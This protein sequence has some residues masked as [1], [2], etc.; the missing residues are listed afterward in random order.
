MDSDAMQLLDRIYKAWP[1][2][3]D[4]RFEHYANR[5]LTHLIKLC[6]VCCI[7]RLGTTIEQED[8]I[9]ANTILS[10]TEQLMPKA[11]GEFGKSKRSEVTH[12]IMAA[13]DKSLKPITLQELWKVVHQDLE[14]RQQMVDI[15]G[16]LQMAE[17]IQAVNNGWLPNK[18]VIEESVKGSVNWDLLTPQEKELTGEL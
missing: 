14:T 2:L 6:L 15:L 17:K 10:F 8:V 18:K 13:I 9:Y 1:G 11:L 7:S 4:L 3:S 12:K 5:R 16:N